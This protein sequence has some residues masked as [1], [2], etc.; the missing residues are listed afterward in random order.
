MTATLSQS[1]IRHIPFG[2]RDYP[3]DLPI[4]IE[5]LSD[6]E[7][8]SPW[9]VILHTPTG[10]DR[11][12]SGMGEVPDWFPLILP[13]LSQ[14]LFLKENWDSYGARRI[15]PEAVE[16]AVSILASLPRN[17]PKPAIVPTSEG[18]IQLEWHESGIDLEL[19]V[20]RRGL[21][22]VYFE[23]CIHNI[24]KAFDPFEIFD[25]RPLLAPLIK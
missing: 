24:S 19:E 11:R 25:I 17:V 8:Y 7:M 21:Q 13:A 6:S 3:H 4:D 5:T 10:D 15:F 16:S 14:C 18:N 22:H 12:V 1:D 9:F 2:E 23:D 20:G